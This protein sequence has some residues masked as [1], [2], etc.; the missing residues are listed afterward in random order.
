VASASQVA[1]VRDER[2]SHGRG[3]ESARGERAACAH[4]ADSTRRLVDEFQQ[5]AL[6]FLFSFISVNSQFF[7]EVSV[8]SQ[9][10]LAIIT[11]LLHDVLA[12]SESVP[13]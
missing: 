8:N 7:F 3:A 9:L 12:D 5:V 2:E 1:R 4:E 11:W 6:F 10:G 13:R